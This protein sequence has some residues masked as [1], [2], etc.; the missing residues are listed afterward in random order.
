M[1]GKLS[2]C[3]FVLTPDRGAVP[4]DSLSDAE[5]AA[6][7]ERLRQRLGIQMA[8]YYS[9]HPEAIAPAQVA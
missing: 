4:V 6:W 2:C 5:K 9:Q 7:H 1:A 8:E 3:S